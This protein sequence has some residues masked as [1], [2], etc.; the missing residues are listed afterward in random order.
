MPNFAEFASISGQ[1]AQE[2]QLKG[3]SFIKQEWHANMKITNL[4]ERQ[5]ED[6]MR[7]LLSHM[8]SNYQEIVVKKEFFSGLTASRVLLLRPLRLDGPELP[9][10]VKI[11]RVAT[12][13]REWRA[14]QVWIANRLP[15]A[16]DIRGNPILLPGEDWAGIIYPLAGAGTF[17]VVSLQQF[18][19]NSA[20]DVVQAL[21]QER[22]GPILNKLWQY[23]QVRPE[24]HVQTAYDAFLPMNLTIELAQPTT[25]Q[26]VLTLNPDNVRFQACQT[27]D[28][29]RLEGFYVDRVWWERNQ[30]SLDIPLERKAAFR[31]RIE[32]VPDMALYREGESLPQPLVGKVVQ[33]RQEELQTMAQTAVGTHIDLSQ[34]TLYLPN[35]TSLP[36]PLHTLPHL[37]NQSLAVR[38]SAIHGDLNMENVLVEKDGR[39]VYLI[40]FAKARQD[41]VLR[42]LIHLESAIITK[43]LP[44]VLA[45]AEFAPYKIVTLYQQ[46]HCALVHHQPIAPPPALK[47]IFVLLQT[48]RENGRR[49]LFTPDDWHEYYIGLTIYL[50]GVLK[51]ADLDQ[52]P[53]AKATAFWGASAVQQLLQE[54]IDC[55]AWLPKTEQATES[56]EENSIM[57]EKVTN[58]TTFTGSVTGPIHTGSG[59]IYIGDQ[60]TPQT[61]PQRRV[62]TDIFTQYEWGIRRLKEQLQQQ[63]R[64]DNPSHHLEQ[65]LLE[66]LARSRR[67]GDTASRQ[68]DRAEIIDELNRIALT[69][70][71]ISFNDLIQ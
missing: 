26:A 24:F 35:G 47:K 71:S 23:H 7:R 31:M 56:Q 41:H 19:E 50:L 29:V 8:F 43:L 59:N 53:G 60:G 21:W 49:Y 65:R 39:N 38:V 58:T 3:Y 52:I 13:Q 62:S 33:V 16:A 42:D 36:N 2:F 5:L 27:G 25:G 9:V 46:L 17:D 34:S 11:D 1:V 14:Y 6:H 10:V 45:Q 51:F 20:P 61:Q 40:D 68:A 67:Y 57:A 63:G 18:I 22:L 32:A 64:D 12:I 55:T 15:N 70:L 30:L 44:P 37:L 4:T 54:T 66:N 48:L 69:Y 28:F